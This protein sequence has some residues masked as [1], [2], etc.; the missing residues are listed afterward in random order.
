MRICEAY[1]PSLQSVNSSPDTLEAIQSQ[2][3]ELAIDSRLK[4]LKA[5]SKDD[6]G[7]N[8]L[9]FRYALLVTVAIVSS[10]VQHVIAIRYP[11]IAKALSSVDDA[12]NVWCIILIHKANH[13]MYTCLCAPCIYC[14]RTSKR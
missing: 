10:F 12:I 8:E 11:W 4:H 1:K 13:A 6:G 9:I 5:K 14:C 2:S 3:S 7:L